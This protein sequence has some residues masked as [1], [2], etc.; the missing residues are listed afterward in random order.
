MHFH[1]GIYWKPS[2]LEGEGIL[3][4]VPCSIDIVFFADTMYHMFATAW[5][6]TENRHLSIYV[7]RHI[8][9]K[10]QTC[11]TSLGCSLHHPF[12]DERTNNIKQ[13]WGSWGCCKFGP[14][15][16][17]PFQSAGVWWLWICLVSPKDG[18]AM[19]I[20]Y[21][22]VLGVFGIC[23]ILGLG[24]CTYAGCCNHK[25]DL[26]VS[27]LNMRNLLAKES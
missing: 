23:W 9:L 18:D 15:M 7:C 25:Y 1:A 3:K 22:P 19:V 16:P 6:F 24:G 17:W 27:L 8:F 13:S 20:R 12:P 4:S 2:V 21:D 5:M 14:G 11:C 26:T 10:I